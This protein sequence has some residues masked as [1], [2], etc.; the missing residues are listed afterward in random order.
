MANVSSL[1]PIQS[2]VPA[3]HRSWKTEP[4]GP[5]DRP[6]DIWFNANWVPAYFS[7]IK[8]GDFFLDIKVDLEQGRCFLATTDV[9][10]S[11]WK[12]VPSFVTQGLEVVQ[13][14]AIS[15][16]IAIEGPSTNTKLLENK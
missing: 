7:D 3:L 10:R 16:T 14:P 1:V 13:A 5:N 9:C 12:G 8:K 15:T 4:D 6:V 11:V 2:S